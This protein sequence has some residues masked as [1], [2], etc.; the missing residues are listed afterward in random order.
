MKEKKLNWKTLGKV[1]DFIDKNTAGLSMIGSFLTFALTLYCAFKASDD[2]ADIHEDY[3]EKVKEI[4]SNGLSEAEKAKEIKELKLVRNVKYV[5]AEKYT[6]ASAVASVALEG[7]TYH[8]MR[9][10][11]VGL[12]ALVYSQRDKLQSL[13]KHA[14]EMIG[15]EKFKEIENLTLEDLVMKNFIEE[16]G[17]GKELNFKALCMDA[18]AKGMEVFLDTMSGTLFM[19][20][21]QDVLDSFKWAEN[22]MVREVFLSQDKWCSHGNYPKPKTPADQFLVWGPKNPFKAHIGSRSL[23]NDSMT[24]Q[25]IEFDNEPMV[26]EKKNSK[27]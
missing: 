13:T 16:N 25:S 12:S 14:K 1:G 19:A 23:Y 24:V 2:V 20:R 11:I 5:K 10:E 17:E 27:W 4:E 22:E 21:R 7:L 26:Y 15:E 3:L 8:S 9:V 18:Q 6:I